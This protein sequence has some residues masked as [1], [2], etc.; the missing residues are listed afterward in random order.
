MPPPSNPTL[1]CLLPMP[2]TPV[3]PPPLCRLGRPEGVGIPVLLSNV[4]LRLAVGVIKP[5]I[6]SSPIPLPEADIEWLI[7]IDTE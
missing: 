2:S 7:D 5:M 6:S 3:A 1:L 4:V